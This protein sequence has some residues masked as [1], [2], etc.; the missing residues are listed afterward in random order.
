M[1]ARRHAGKTNHIRNRSSMTMIHPTTPVVGRPPCGCTPPGGQ[2]T[3][4]VCIHH[5]DDFEFIFVHYDRTGTVELAFPPCDFTMELTTDTGFRTYTAG[6]RNGV[7]FNLREDNG[8]IRVMCNA[9][10]LPPGDMQCRMTLHIPDPAMPDGIRDQCD[11]FP[12]GIRLVT[13]RA[14][15]C[16][17][18]TDVAVVSARLPVLGMEEITQAEVAAMFEQEEGSPLSALRP[19]TDEEIDS[20]FHGEETA[21][22]HDTAEGDAQGSPQ[23]G[24]QP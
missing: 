20:I 14:C 7:P 19:A 13:E 11:A 1:A 4:P 5:L 10:R 9:H 21:A 22:A 12:L 3:P 23:E 24:A 17:A 8:R 15:R 2:D 18:V 16:A 6:V